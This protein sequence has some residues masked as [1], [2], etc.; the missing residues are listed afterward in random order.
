VVGGEYPE[1]EAL[2][3]SYGV[4]AENQFAMLSDDD[5]QLPF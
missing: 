2:L 4:P 5:A 1:T 3:Q